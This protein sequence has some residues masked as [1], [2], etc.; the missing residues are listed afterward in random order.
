LER[1]FV[2]QGHALG[3]ANADRRRLRA[4][5]RADHRE[6]VHRQSSLEALRLASVAYQVPFDLLYRRASCESMGS[7]PADPPSERTLN[8]YAANP[9]SSARGL[10][11]FLTTPNGGTW[12]TTPFAGFSVYSPYA[13]AFAGA[14]MQAHGRGGEWVCQ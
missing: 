11:Q 5:L 12:A 7:A 8:A 3:R 13:S 2:A 10:M 9:S 6:L 14:W 4:L 1:R